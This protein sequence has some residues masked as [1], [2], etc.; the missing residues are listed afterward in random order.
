MDYNHQQQ[1]EYVYYVAANTAKN[2]E[3]VKREVRSAYGG[4][5]EANNQ[6]KSCGNGQEVA[7]VFR[8]SLIV[9]IR[10]N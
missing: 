3:D 4:V 10:K 9:D 1:T 7:A 5:A 2:T 8:Q 6:K